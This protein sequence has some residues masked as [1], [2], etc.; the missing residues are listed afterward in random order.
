[1][2]YTASLSKMVHAD[3]ISAFSARQGRGSKVSKIMRSKMSQDKT[4]AVI[5]C[6]AKVEVSA[7]PQY[8]SWSPRIMVE[9]AA[10]EGEPSHEK[11]IR[12]ARS[13]PV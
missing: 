11:E 10:V 1:L 12:V 7:D 4:F 2:D 8:R 13:S 3:L 9:A 5:T 6:E